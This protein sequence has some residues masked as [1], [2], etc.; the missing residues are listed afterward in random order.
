MLIKGKPDYKLRVQLVPF[1]R[2]STG[3]WMQD[4][5]IGMTLYNTEK[6]DV[7]RLK[8]GLIKGL[9]EAFK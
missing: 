3:M 6:F 9:D 1:K 7:E 5:S 8:K 4:K 2:S